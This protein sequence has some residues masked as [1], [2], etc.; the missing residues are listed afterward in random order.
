MRCC[1]PSAAVPRPE[2]A[3]RLPLP[4][5]RVAAPLVPLAELPPGQRRLLDALVA[6]LEAG[7]FPTFRQ[8]ADVLGVRVHAVHEHVKRLTRKGWLTHGGGARQVALGPAARA[9]L[10]GARPDGGHVLLALYAT[11]ERLTPRQARELARA[12]DAAAGAVE[13]EA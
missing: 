6:A 4:D 8:M 10:R 11:A 12:L 13:G 7:Q 3:P 9:A 1:R 2:R 5:L